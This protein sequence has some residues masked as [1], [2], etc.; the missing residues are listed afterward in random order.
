MDKIIVF[1]SIFLFVFIPASI[2]AESSA[3]LVKLSTR[4]QVAEQKLEAFKKSQNGVLAAQDK[5]I[6]EIKN[7]KIWVNKNRH[8]GISS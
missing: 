5:I 4:L 3:E 8:G 1:S 7:L 6:E 2:S